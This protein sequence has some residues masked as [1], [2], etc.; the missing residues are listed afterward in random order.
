MKN[1]LSM[2]ATKNKDYPENISFISTTQPSSHITY[3]NEAF[4]D[5]AEYSLDDLL[6]QPHNM[7][8]HPDMPK[9]A[10]E[11]LWH[12]LNQGH[13]WMGIVKNRC[14]GPRHYW[15]SAFVTPIKDAQ[16]NIVEHQSVRSKPSKEQ[17]ARAE[18]LYAKLNQGES[19][20]V[21]RW[22]VMR[23]MQ[24]AAWLGLLVSAGWM[25]QQHAWLPGSALL[26]IQ[27][28]VL[29]GLRHLHKRHAQLSQLSREAYSNP[30]MEKVYTGHCD[31]CSPVELALMMRKAELRAV[32]AR[33]SETSGQTLK[34]AQRELGNTRDIEQALVQQLQ[35]TE[36]VATAVEEL[37]HSINDIA[38]SASAASQLT[39]I[40]QH[41]SLCGLARI[42]D[43]VVQ[44]NALDSE[45]ADSQT[46]LT[47]LAKHSQQVETILDVISAISE[48]T[49]LLALNAAIEAARAGESGRGFAVV[50]DEVRQLAAKTSASTSEIHTMIAELQSLATQAVA[51]MQRGSALSSACKQAA[52]STGG[53]IQDIAA[54]LGQVTLESQQIAAA[55][56]QQA[57]ATREITANAVNI[58][59]LTQQN[60]D[61][62]SSSVQ[63]TRHLVHNL[64]QLQR[65]IHQF[66]RH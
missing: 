63:R 46:I 42:R 66:E 10:F 27:L 65:L 18:A 55:V 64:E 21:R 5:I 52:D 24:G 58:K 47:T 59:T 16:G 36:Q 17:I 60:S 56:E 13:S 41:D 62:S 2:A 14:K 6:T 48:Q 34:D 8:R 28:S 9:A 30:L 29:L 61:A 35:E 45:L 53:V 40:A 20:S 39:E 37:T 23:L 31:E 43:T 49:N 15:V 54:K 4:C 3:A 51:S 44:V 25:W 57:S 11:Q 50:A 38:N 19:V 1:L 22:P 26:G 12:Y 32:V 7:V 33:S